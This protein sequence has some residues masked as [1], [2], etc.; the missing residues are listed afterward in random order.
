MVRFYI[1]FSNNISS[2]YFY[3]FS[4]CIQTKLLLDLWGKRSDRVVCE[5]LLLSFFPFISWICVMWKKESISCGNRDYVG[6][7]MARRINRFHSIDYNHHSNWTTF[8]SVYWIHVVVMQHPILCLNIHNTF[9]RW[10]RKSRTSCSRMFH[11]LW[12]IIELLVNIWAE[13]ESDYFLCNGSY[14]FVWNGYYR[15]YC[16]CKLLSDFGARR[17]LGRSRQPVFTIIW[18]FP[19]T[20]RIL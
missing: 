12:W 11:F 19:R 2:R 14:Y 13:H 6:F 10:L 15:K 5:M 18:M 4:L 17:V 7:N 3:Q 8:C 16:G 20:Q 9:C 1:N